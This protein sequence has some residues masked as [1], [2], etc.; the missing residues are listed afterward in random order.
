MFNVKIQRDGKNP[1]LLLI[2][3]VTWLGGET[4]KTELLLLNLNIFYICIS[5][6]K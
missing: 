4:S 3:L 1:R 2:M 5:T 6:I